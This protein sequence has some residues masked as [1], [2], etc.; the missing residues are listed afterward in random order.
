MEI[1]GILGPVQSCDAWQCGYLTLIPLE[2]SSKKCFALIVVI[3]TYRRCICD[4]RHGCD[5]GDDSIN[6]RLQEPI[7]S[8]CPNICAL[9]DG[10]PG[11]SSWHANRGARPQERAIRWIQW[12]QCQCSHLEATLMDWDG[13]LVLTRLWQFWWRKT[14]SVVTFLKVF[15]HSSFTCKMA[16][17]QSW[18]NTPSITTVGMSTS[19]DQKEEL[20]NYL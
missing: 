14:T 20:P 17:L 18:I 2:T 13:L 19:A 15:W 5:L 10:L 16:V 12:A 3:L 7:V 11:G 9:L 1:S 8:L 6:W 4:V